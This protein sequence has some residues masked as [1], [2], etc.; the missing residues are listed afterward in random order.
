MCGAAED[1]VDV[2]VRAYWTRCEDEWYGEGNGWRR[3]GDIDIIACNI[4]TT[5]LLFILCVYFV[6]EY[7]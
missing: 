2:P 6:S 1:V 3:V 5:N 4:F 7:V